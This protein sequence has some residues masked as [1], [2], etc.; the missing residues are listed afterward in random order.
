VPRGLVCGRRLIE[1]LQGGG[2]RGPS[3]YLTCGGYL[4]VSGQYLTAVPGKAHLVRANSLP[5]FCLDLR[6]PGTMVTLGSGSCLG[7]P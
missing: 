2:C 6:R 5:C 4:Q 1:T 7:H 3:A